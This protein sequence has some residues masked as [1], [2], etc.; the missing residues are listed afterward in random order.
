MGVDLMIYTVEGY[1]IKDQ[2]MVKK[3]NA[4]DELVEAGCFTCEPYGMTFG[5]LSLPKCRRIISDFYD[6]EA[7]ASIVA[8]KSTSEVFFSKITI[9]KNTKFINCKIR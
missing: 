6:P 1:L 5:I 2:D 8:E 4:I 3:L 9:K 7:K